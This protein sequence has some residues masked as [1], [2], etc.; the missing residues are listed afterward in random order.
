MVANFWTKINLMADDLWN[1]KQ[2]KHVLNE[3]RT[4]ICFDLGFINIINANHSRIKIMFSLH[5][6]KSRI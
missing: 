5:E 4:E 6:D 2:F 1:L 3:R